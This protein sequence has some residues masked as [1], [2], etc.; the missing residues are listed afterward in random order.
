VPEGATNRRGRKDD[1]PPIPGWTGVGIAVSGAAAPI[2]GRLPV[3]PGRVGGRG[4]RARRRP[5]RGYRR[6]DRVQQPVTAVRARSD[7]AA[8]G[9]TAE[10]VAPGAPVAVKD[11]GSA[12]VLRATANP[13]NSRC[14]NPPVVVATSVV[15]YHRRL[16]RIREGSTCEDRRDDDRAAVEIFERTVPLTRD[17]RG[18]GNRLRPRL[19]R[20]SPSV[21]PVSSG[22][23]SLCPL[24]SGW[25][26]WRANDRCGARIRAEPGRP[27]AGGRPVIRQ[28]P[29]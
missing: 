8:A 9:K 23:T 2:G 1:P 16:A 24:L 19:R 21:F 11:N 17:R 22:A 20:Y 15:T 25:W 6:L 12:V 7:P 5:G 13:A 10:N 14:R 3:R 18:R 29:R 4:C 26:P 28:Y 27:A